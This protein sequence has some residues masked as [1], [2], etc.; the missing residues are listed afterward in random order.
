M[1]RRLGGREVME[2][3]RSMAT[4]GFVRFS[5]LEFIQREIGVWNVGLVLTG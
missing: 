3:R 1:R 5:D 2:V 4:E